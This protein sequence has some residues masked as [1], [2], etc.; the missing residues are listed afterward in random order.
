MGL[1]KTV[2]GRVKYKPNTFIGGVSATIN[3]PA[4]I[5]ARFGIS[6]DRIKVFN[7]IGENIQFTITG[8]KFNFPY[9]PSNPAFDNEPTLTYFK[10]DGRFI[11]GVANSE[12]SNNPKLTIL[13]LYGLKSFG[14]GGA[15]KISGTGI[16]DL[17]FP[18]MTNITGN[19]SVTSNAFLKTFNAPIATYITD[20][21]TI[22]NNP[23]L[24]Y[25]NIPNVTS[26]G[27]T[28]TSSNSFGGCKI[29]CIINV[30]PVLL[31]CNNGMPDPDLMDVVNA[32]YA[33]INGIPSDSGIAL[34]LRKIVST[35]VGNCIRVRRSTD[36]IEMDIGFV[37]DVLDTSTLLTF[38]G[39]GNGYIVRWFD[40]VGYHRDMYQSLPANQPMIVDSGVLVA[41]NGKPAIKCN[42][43]QFLSSV[44]D[45]NLSGLTDIMSGYVVAAKLSDGALVNVEGGAGYNHF[46]VGGNNI[47]FRH[48]STITATIVDSHNLAVQNLYQI[49]RYSGSAT[50]Y[51]RNNILKADAAMN[52][53]WGLRKFSIGKAIAGNVNYPDSSIYQE[54]RYYRSDIS[55]IQDSLNAEINSFYN[56]Y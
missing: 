33:V 13:E 51:F 14:P 26:I 22:A 15:P 3:T 42:S 48:N 39:S 45:V 21:S 55:N 44:A 9:S 24:E 28:S 49:I 34:S 30:S 50:K 38:V 46:N 25:I 11:I 4:L 53:T 41:L 32:R 18:E 1:Q 54:I 10:D 23:Q 16:V 52:G 19:S 17:Y 8:A 5:A 7:I 29:G 37:N 43:V 36:N 20:G 6:A 40:Q 12:F 27:A 56:I 47:L 31:S 35:Y 2:F